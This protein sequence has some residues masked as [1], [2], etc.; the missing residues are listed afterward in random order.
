MNDLTYDWSLADYPIEKNGLKV[1]STFSCGG[2]STMGYKLAGYEVIAANDIDPQMQ[3]VYLANHSPKY[4]LLAP[5]KDLIERDI[6]EELYGIDVLDGSPPCSVFSMVGSREKA[7]GK[8]KVFREGQAK[9]ILDDLFFDF[10]KLVEKIKPKIVIAENVEGM[11]QGNAKWYTRE[12]HRQMTALGYT[13]QIFLF[14]GA[15]MGLPQKRKRVFFIYHRKDFDLPKLQIS[16]S[17]L[18]VQYKTIRQDQGTEIEKITPLYKEYWSHV[19]S[20][21]SVG[22]FQQVKKTGLQQV[23]YT[24]TAGQLPFDSLMP[25]KLYLEE[26]LKISSFPRDYNFLNVKPNYLM[27]MSVPPLMMAKVSEQVYEQWGSKL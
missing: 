7:W 26:I 16:F 6:P 18:P 8:D 23:P 25:R 24:L 20:R 4:Y 13:G 9:Q 5:V 21:Q 15:D 1:F 12:V 14:N 11:L 27:G 19:G 2:G 3:K 17:E 10:I 22:K